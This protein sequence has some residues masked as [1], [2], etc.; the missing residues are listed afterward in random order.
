MFQRLLQYIQ[1]NV[2]DNGQLLSLSATLNYHKT[3]Q[4]SYEME[5]KG[6]IAKNLKSRLSNHFKL[7]IDFNLK[8]NRVYILFQ[9]YRYYH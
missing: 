3:L 8:R 9:N 5:V 4:E 6:Y 1:T 2:I 7:Q